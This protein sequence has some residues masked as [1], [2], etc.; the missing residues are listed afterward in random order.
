M[1]ADVFVPGQW[2]KPIQGMPLDEALASGSQQSLSG[3]TDDEAALQ[4]SDVNLQAWTQ[5]EYTQQYYVS[6]ASNI[7]FDVFSIVGACSWNALHKRRSLC[8]VG[9]DQC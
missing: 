5:A 1:D 7:F 3:L 4:G 6:Q 9:S 2:D 8:A